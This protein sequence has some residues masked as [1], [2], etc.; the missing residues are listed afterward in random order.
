MCPQNP[1]WSVAVAPQM[2]HSGAHE[3]HRCGPHRVVLFCPNTVI[4]SPAGTAYVGC[5]A[6]SIKASSLWL[7]D[8]LICHLGLAPGTPRHR[9]QYPE[10][11]TSRTILIGSTPEGHQ[12]GQGGDRLGTQTCRST[13]ARQVRRS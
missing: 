13:P 4:Q 1:S 12:E 2:A 7:R 9:S 10:V 8:S 6:D 11:S 5:Y 3:V